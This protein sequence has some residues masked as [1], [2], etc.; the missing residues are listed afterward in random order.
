MGAWFLTGL[1]VLLAVQSR[2]TD[3]SGFVRDQSNGES[4]PFVNIYL[5]EENRG[6]ISNESGY[7]A[8]TRI[9][10]GR[11]TLIAT[12]IGYKAFEKE[13]QVGTEDIVLDISLQE[14][15]IELKT[16]VV[17]AERDEVESFE[18][19]PGRTV[20]QVKELK[21]APAAIEA[22][23]IRTIQT[24]PGVATLSDGKLLLVGGDGGDA[25]VAYLFN[26]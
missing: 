17:E 20:L 8:I 26:P 5:V 24:L 4:L 16:T 6:S 2:A 18:I 11:H 1:V 14:E 13:I 25:Q 23:P 7:Y 9:P 3:I 21:T 15:I 12:S 22:D 10:P 19:S